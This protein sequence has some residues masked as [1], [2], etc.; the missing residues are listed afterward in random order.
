MRDARVYTITN[1]VHVY[2]T[3]MYTNMAAVATFDA[4]KLKINCN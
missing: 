3:I 4:Q 2:K 1:C